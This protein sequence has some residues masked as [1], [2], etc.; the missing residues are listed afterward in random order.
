MVKNLSDNYY[1]YDI[2][3]EEDLSFQLSSLLDKIPIWRK[4]KVMSYKHDID[5]YLCAKSFM[6]LKEGLSRDYYINDDIH[7]SYNRY[8]KPF[9]LGHPEIHFNLSHC[10]KG[11][12]CA[13]SYNPVGIDIE[14]IVYDDDIAKFI[15]SEDEYEQV[16]S[17][18]NPA[19]SFTKAWTEKESYAKMIGCGLLDNMKALRVKNAL[20]STKINRNVGYIVTVCSSI[21]QYSSHE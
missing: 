21:K 15:F 18:P 11:V 13:I 12:A 5:K 3:L 9:L 7:F 20:F 6:L 10:R 8:G 17:S 16:I 4:E 19:E 14:E 2:L 1:V